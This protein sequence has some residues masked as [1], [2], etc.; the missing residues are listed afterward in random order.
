MLDV[1]L[2]SILTGQMKSFPLLLIAAAVFLYFLPSMLAFL[3]GHRRF[4]VILALN[5]LVT[6]VQ[7]PILLKLFPSLFA[8][9]PGDITGMLLVGA[10][11]NFGPGWLILLVWALN[12]GEPDQR[13]LRAQDSKLYDVIAAL[14]LILWFAY[15]AWQIRPYIINDIVL[16]TTGRASLFAWV[17]LFSLSA[18]AGFNLLLVYLL[19]I[20]DKP[21]RKSKGWLPRFCAFMGTFL[22]VGMLQ[23]PVVQLTLSMQILTALLIGIGSLAS[24]L[25]LWRLGKSFSIMPEARTLVTAGPYA[26]ARHPLYAVEMITIVGMALQFAQP[27]AALLTLLVLSFLVLRTVFEERVLVEAFPDYVAYRAKTARFIPGII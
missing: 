17:Q 27:W 14:P 21:V 18:A 24:V 10:I 9:T 4:F 7:S 25:V 1:I 6:F 23:L 16:I 22:G 26:H 15:G 12:P 3:K 8:I 19:I 13:L 5:F 2:K 20:R 11:A